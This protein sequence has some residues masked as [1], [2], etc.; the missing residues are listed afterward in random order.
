MKLLEYTL[1]NRAHVIIGEYMKFIPIGSN[2]LDIGCGNGVISK[3]IADSL[4]CKVTGTDILDY[5]TTEIDFCQI[6]DEGKLPFK[7]NAFDMVM[8]NDVL[9]HMPYEMQ[10]KIILEAMRVGKET[11]IFELRPTLYAKF[12]DW[13]A[14]KMHNPKVRVSLTQRTL[15]GWETMFK[16][17]NINYNSFVIRR[18]FQKN[19]SHSKR[20]R[21]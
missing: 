21:T 15:E 13:F 20:M 1:K 11:I 10:P 2:V 3:M 8:F 7:D 5:R 18:K 4:K 19:S 12:T 9:H 6:K 17:N 16:E 14:N